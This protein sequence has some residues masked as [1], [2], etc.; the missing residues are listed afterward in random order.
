MGGWLVYFYLSLRLT[1][2]VIKDGPAIFIF[3]HPVLGTLVM[4][5]CQTNTSKNNMLITPTVGETETQ[6]LVALVN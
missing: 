4:T 6:L 1:C 3:F 2:T 5:H